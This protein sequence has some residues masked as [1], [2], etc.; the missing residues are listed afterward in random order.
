ML[1]WECC[2]KSSQQGAQEGAKF[3]AQHLIT[4]TDVAFDDFA[5]AE[6]DAFRNR[7]ILGLDT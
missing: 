6:A 3:I 1:E 7:R 2:L 5:G 4:A